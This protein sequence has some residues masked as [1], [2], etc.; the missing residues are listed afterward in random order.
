MER[1]LNPAGPWEDGA[2]YVGTEPEYHV[3]PQETT[4]YDVH[5]YKGLAPVNTAVLVKG[6][7]DITLDFSGATLMLHGKLQAFV[8]DNC[9]NITVRNV[10]ILNDRAAFTEGTIIENGGDFLTLRLNPCHPCRIEDGRLI[11]TSEYWENDTLDRTVMF[12]Q[13]FDAKTREG[14]GISLCMIGKV[15]HRENLPFQFEQLVAEETP[16]G[17][18]RLNGKIAECFQPG[19]IV[20]IGHERRHLSTF[21]IRE[22]RNVRLENVRILN[23]PG[24]GIMPI[25]SRDIYLDRVQF[26]HCE[27][28]Q[29]IITNHADALHTFACGGDL[30]LTDCVFEGMIDD[31][32]N[33]HGQFDLLEKCEGDRLT[34]KQTIKGETTAVTIF[35]AGDRIGVHCGKATEVEAEYIVREANILDD[36]FVEL[37]LDRPVERAHESGSLVENFSAQCDLTM[38]RCAFRKANTHLRIQTSGKVRIEECEIALEVLLTGDGS[39]WFESSGVRDMVVRD[40]AFTSVKARFLATPQVF[41]TKKEPYYH[42]NIRIER[43][44]FTTDCPIEARLTDN[45]V[46]TDN[47]QV[48]GKPMTL[49][50]TNCGSAYAPGCMIERRTEKVE[51]LQLN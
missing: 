46:F 21:F 10:D 50:L 29:G 16:D 5:T 13:C 14:C 12:L 17:L 49:K 2:T 8:L 35:G 18:L 6:K 45:I 23:G 20:V 41:P 30:A 38:R 4:P 43:C 44:S 36:D 25:H 40:T 7:R 22:C 47:T 15:I 1:K 32:I 24:M 37:V 48:D 9:E 3:R 26:T 27:K 39:F 34:V 11:P 28:S 51:E 33:V 31:A 19:R 42:K